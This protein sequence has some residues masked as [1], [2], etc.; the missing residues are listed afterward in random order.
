[1]HKCKYSYRYSNC[2]A[3]LATYIYDYLISQTLIWLRRSEIAIISPH[4]QHFSLTGYTQVGNKVMVICS[5]TAIY[6]YYIQYIGKFWRH[7]FSRM[8][9]LLS[10]IEVEQYIFCVVKIFRLQENWQKQ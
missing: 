7:K 8:A 4:R 5:S 6:T 10:L 1:M 2:H 9:I 3:Y